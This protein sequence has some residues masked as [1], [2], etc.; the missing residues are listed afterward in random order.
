MVRRPVLGEAV[1]C[2][3]SSE[4]RMERVGRG[5]GERSIINRRNP[6]KA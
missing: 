6:G 3:I 5:E 2:E 4:E 1:V